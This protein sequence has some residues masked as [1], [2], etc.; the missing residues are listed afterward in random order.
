MD[1]TRYSLLSA[2]K[3]PDNQAAWAEFYDLY[4]GFVRSVAR[5]A[6]VELTPEDVEEVVQRVFIE[7]SQGKVRYEKGQGRFRALLKTTARRRCIDQFRKRRA[8]PDQYKQKHRSADDDRATATMDRLL[9]ERTQVDEAIEK[10]EWAAMVT[11]MAKQATK[12]RVDPKQ[13][14][15]FEAYVLREWEVSQVADTLGVTANQVYL[16]KRRVGAVYAEEAK[17]AAERLDDPKIPLNE[18]Q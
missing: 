18:A 14:Q 13:Y 8:R 16:A 3:N 2:V 17:I 5:S 4:S 12:A 7:I 1:S 10:K 15:I 11:D 6:S 9:D